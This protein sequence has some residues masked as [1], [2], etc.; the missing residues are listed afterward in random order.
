MPFRKNVFIL[1]AGFSANA[2]APLMKDFMERANGLWLDPRLGL[3]RE[4]HETFESVFDFLR[5]LDSAQARITLD[6]ENIEHLF[7]LAEMDLEFGEGGREGFRQ[8][9][10]SLILQTL[11]RSMGQGPFGSVPMSVVW[12]PGSR[13]SRNVGANYGELF[14]ALASRRWLGGSYGWENTLSSDRICRD[15]I[16]TMNYDCFTDDALLKLGIRPDYRLPEEAYPK[17]FTDLHFRMSLLKLH[18]STNWFRCDSGTCN[19]RIFVLGGG[20]SKRQE[21]LFKRMPCPRCGH[22]AIEPV[23]VP[24][25]WTKGNYREMLTPVWSHAIQ[26]IREAGRIF[27]IG[28]SMP[29]SDTFFQ[30][31]LALAL[32]ENHDIYRVIVVNRN[33]HTL[34]RYGGLFQ[35]PF[36]ERR[37]VR[38]QLESAFFVRDHML[39]TLEQRQEG[40]DGFERRAIEA[41]NFKWE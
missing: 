30:Y 19:G 18:G 4:H 40:D 1:G 8:H 17:D 6:F 27:I 9:L 13:S 10:L 37:L 38:M 15:T 35:Q 34:D 25:A 16:I 5:R 26:A 2:G 39:A 33:S 31:M 29:E 23:I 20:T 7:G 3:P 28:Y 24:P 12:S 32:K 11:E 36:R 21:Y 14:A 22:A 41:S